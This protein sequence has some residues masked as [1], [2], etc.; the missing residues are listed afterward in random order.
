MSKGRVQQIGT[1]YEVYHWPENMFVGGFIGSP[2]M[3]F[4]SGRIQD[5]RFIASG[6]D[7]AVPP[8]LLAGLGS[9][10]NDDLILGIRPE[11][12]KTWSGEFHEPIKATI[13]SSEYLGNHALLYVTM[14]ETRCIVNLSLDGA[15]LDSAELYIDM[16][17][18]HFFDPKSEKRIRSQENGR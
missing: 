2:P 17:G 3:N 9:H 5:G 8:N 18:A 12:F 13:T 1:P 10:I 11:N 7:L 16:K 6:L 14:E 15:D 4:I